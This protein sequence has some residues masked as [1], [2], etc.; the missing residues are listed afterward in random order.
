MSQ[1]H[2][3]DLQTSGD[4][5]TKTSEGYKGSTLALSHPGVLSIALDR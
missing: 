1:N 5:A 4:V 2:A 3:L